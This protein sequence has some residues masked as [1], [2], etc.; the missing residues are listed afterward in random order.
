MLISFPSIL[1]KRTRKFTLK[2][3]TKMCV[4]LVHGVSL[5][6]MKDLPAMGFYTEQAPSGQQELKNKF[7][8]VHVICIFDIDLLEI[9]SKIPSFMQVL[10]TYYAHFMDQYNFCYCHFS[11]ILGE[12]L[13]MYADF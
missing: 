11:F 12:T 1:T 8:A 5:L 2:G 13:K 6:S 3:G 10:Y 7:G 9:F 4:S